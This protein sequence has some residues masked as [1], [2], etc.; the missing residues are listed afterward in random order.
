MTP[1]AKLLLAL[2]L[3]TFGCGPDAA[4][5]VPESVGA[6]KGAC[7]I[8]DH[9]DECKVESENGN[10]ELCTEKCE[11]QAGL[12][13]IW[14]DDTSGPRCVVKSDRTLEGIRACNVRCQN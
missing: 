12:G 4:P 14:T 8:F 3:V 5:E 10:I 9:H 7:M 13:Y 1:Y 6:C 11:Y 2:P